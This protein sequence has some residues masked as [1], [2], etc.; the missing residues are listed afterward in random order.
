MGRTPGNAASSSAPATRAPLGLA[1]RRGKRPRTAL[2]RPEAW[3]RRASGAR[4]AAVP[5]A[6]VDV[7]LFAAA[8]AGAA[9]LAPLAGAIV[10]RVLAALG[11]LDARVGD[12]RGDELDG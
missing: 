5:R 6:L 7:D 8:A 1:P 4:A 11:A 12:P 2:R 3:G 10:A 9:R